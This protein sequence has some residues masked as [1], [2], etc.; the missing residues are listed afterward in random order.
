MPSQ[1]TPRDALEV[2]L[3]APWANGEDVGCGCER[4]EEKR[5]ALATLTALVERAGDET[6]VALAQA[7]E[8]AEYVEQHAKGKMEAAARHFLSMPYAQALKAR[9]LPSAADEA[10]P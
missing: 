8:F 1:M 3:R 6:E 5:Q 7:V 10:K 4:C 2:M 9:I